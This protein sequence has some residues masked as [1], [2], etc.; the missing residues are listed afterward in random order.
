MPRLD[1]LPVLRNLIRLNLLI[2]AVGWLFDSL[3]FLSA[4][5][6]AMRSAFALF[7]QRITQEGMLWTPF[8]YM[9]LHGNLT[10]LVFN[11]MGLYFLGADLERALGS[12][13][14]LLIYLLSGVVGGW[15]F[16]LFSYLYQG[17]VDPV[18]G[19]SGAV[20]GLLGA[21]VALYPRRQYVILPLMIPVRAS[22]LGM[23]LFSSHLFFMF[24]PYGGRVAYDVHLAGGL[25]GFVLAWSM[26]FVHQRRCFRA[27][28]DLN[29]A[30]AKA[31]WEAMLYRLNQ[32][33]GAASFSEA[34]WSRYHVLEEWLRYKDVLRL[35]ELKEDAKRGN[36]T[37][38]RAPA[39]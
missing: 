32:P 8:T 10:H 5:S 13:R 39:S 11:M 30:A 12:I 33:E 28:P 19:A 34:E 24:T 7:P 4:G 15:G 18:V 14:F 16:F 17:D 38:K 37:P 3:G 25:L 21:I 26:A 2:F 29:M 6:A 9:F 1:S 27:H 22:V 20:M 35:E 23:L 31:E 36:S